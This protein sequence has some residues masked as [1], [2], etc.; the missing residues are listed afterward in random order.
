MRRPGA[1]FLASHSQRKLLRNVGYWGKKNKYN[2]FTE[3]S[4]VDL[5]VQTV[6]ALGWWMF[7]VRLDRTDKLLKSQTYSR[8]FL[9]CRDFCFALCRFRPAHVVLR[10]VTAN[11]QVFM[12]TLRSLSRPS[13]DL[14]VKRR[15]FSFFFLAGLL[16]HW[17][18]PAVKWETTAR[19]NSNNLRVKDQ[20]SSAWG[21]KLSGDTPAPLRIGMPR[22]AANTWLLIK[23]SNAGATL[24]ATTRSR[25]RR[26][27]TSVTLFWGI[28]A[29]MWDT[30]QAVLYKTNTHIA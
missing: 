21:G 30:L 28:N 16:V 12:D 15:E 25:I 9:L 19:Q 18:N 26:V 20:P 5:Y 22:Y 4:D 7:L 23:E 11:S 24:V 27:Q 13:C 2:S 14:T 8:R 17:M 1:E 10:C 3:L 29:E 6:S